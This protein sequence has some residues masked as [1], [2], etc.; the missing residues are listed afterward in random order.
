M[1]IADN[2]AGQYFFPMTY[3]EDS[4]EMCQC[5][6]AMLI[7]SVKRIFLAMQDISCRMEGSNVRSI[8][9]R[10]F[11]RFLLNALEISASSSSMSILSFRVKDVL[12]G[13]QCTRSRTLPRARAQPRASALD[14]SYA[15][16]VHSSR[17]PHAPSSPNVDALAPEHSSKRSTESPDSRTLPRLFPHIPRQGITFST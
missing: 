3:N 5:C 10:A 15:P 11:F 17:T 8:E 2:E 9:T 7:S 4:S 1:P 14:A 16:L 6:H 12:S 13:E